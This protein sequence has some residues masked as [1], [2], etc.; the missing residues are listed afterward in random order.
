MEDQRPLHLNRPEDGLRGVDNTNDSN[1]NPRLAELESVHNGTD[2][3]LTSD[4]DV[5]RAIASR[6]AAE[7]D[8]L[9]QI[10]RLV[11][12]LQVYEAENQSLKAEFNVEDH[13][14]QSSK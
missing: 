11:R 5:L 12:E 9:E 4:D 13:Q 10:D 3:S 2:L 7:G 6:T 1:N 14:Q 8:S